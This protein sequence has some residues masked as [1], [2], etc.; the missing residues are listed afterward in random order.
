METCHCGPQLVLLRDYMS[1]EIPTRETA[2]EG[3]VE[4]RG[5]CRQSWMLSVD[6]ELQCVICGEGQCLRYREFMRLGMFALIPCQRNV[7]RLQPRPQFTN[8]EVTDIGGFFCP[9]LG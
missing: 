2:D 1:S 3:G 9:S 8:N 6:I 5:L 4:H 7:L